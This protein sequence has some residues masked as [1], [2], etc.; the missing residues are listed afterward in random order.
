MSK[1]TENKGAIR[2][3]NSVIIAAASLASLDVAGGASKLDDTC[4]QG[5]RILK[6]VGDIFCK[7]LAVG[8]TLIY[9]LA[10]GLTAAEVEEALES[11]PQA[12]DDPPASEQSMRAVFPI[13][14][15]HGGDKIGDHFEFNLRWSV[16]EGNSLLWWIYNPDNDPLSAASQDVIIFAKHFGV[17]LND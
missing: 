1:F 10:V 11:D 7:S 8:E 6:T 17:W 16:K 3:D 5:F 14:S 15:L 12:P 9:G 13:G 4:R 2:Y